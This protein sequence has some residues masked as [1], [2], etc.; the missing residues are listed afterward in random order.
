MA[1]SSLWKQLFFKIHLRRHPFE[2]GFALEYPGLRLKIGS[3]H[4][5]RPVICG[6]AHVP[7]VQE[8][9]IEVLDL[10]G[11]PSLVN[12]CLRKRE[13]QGGQQAQ[14]NNQNQGTFATP[15]D[16]QIFGQQAGAWLLEHFGKR[17]FHVLPPRLQKASPGT[18]PRERALARIVQQCLVFHISLTSVVVDSRA[19]YG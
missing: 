10:N 1:T 5:R 8:I 11:S 4:V 18:L 16:L 2:E 6:R 3:G 14:E 12:W 9:F 19:H 7:R 17:R 13:Q 15:E